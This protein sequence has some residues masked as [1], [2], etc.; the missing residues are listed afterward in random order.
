MIPRSDSVMGN[1][2]L[3]T[4]LIW[5]D[6]PV[7]FIL[8]NEQGYAFLGLA[9]ED[10]TFLYAPVSE[11]RLIAVRTGLVSLREAFARPELNKLLILRNGDDSSTPIAV[12]DVSEEWLPEPDG[13]PALR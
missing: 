8:R 1:V 4:V 11:D 9:V 2:S 7:L 13:W 10:D 12:E 3:D 6:G 5:Y